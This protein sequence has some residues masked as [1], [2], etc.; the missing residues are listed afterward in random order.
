MLEAGD[1]QVQSGAAAPKHKRSRATGMRWVWLLLAL[2]CWMLAL[3]MI[4]S[5]WFCARTD[6]CWERIQRDGVVRV[7]M[8]ATYAPF[9]VQD[10][11]GRFCG[12]D[13][14]LAREL[15][16]RWGLDAEFINIHFDGLYDAL[17]AGKCDLLVSALP[18]DPTMTRDVLY[19]PS[20]LNAG[21]LLIVRE[22]ERDIRSTSG[23][24]GRKVG[25]EVGAAGH[26]EAR[27]LREQ[28]RIPLEMVTLPTSRKVLEALLAGETDAGIVD[29]ISAYRFGRDPGGIRFFEEFLTDEQ[30]VIAMRPHSGYLWKR[31]ADELVR[32]DK[33]GFLEALQD[34]WF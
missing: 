25:V 8:D 22:A 1:R 4:I 17:L 15:A 3:R 12:Y 23:L 7:G 2:C 10:E 18:Y 5:T 9:E 20:Y 26:L 11:T 21:L 32:M 24:A 33:E 28:E 16:R 30:Y 6:P 29:S 19:S 31:V 14:E 13:V 34:R 27:R